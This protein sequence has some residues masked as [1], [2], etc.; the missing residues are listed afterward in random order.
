MDDEDDQDL[1]SP[2]AARGKRTLGG[3]PK[4]S[5]VESD[6]EDDDE[7]Q[8]YVPMTKRVKTEPVEDTFEEEIEVEV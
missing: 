7:E 4:R 6:M 8:S 2:S 1:L 5:Y 3:R